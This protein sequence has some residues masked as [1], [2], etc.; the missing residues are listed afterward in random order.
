MI[1]LCYGNKNDFNYNDGVKLPNEEIQRM[2]DKVVEY[3]IEDNK[4][5][6]RF[7]ATGDTMVIG[8]AFDEYDTKEPTSIEIFVCKNY[9]HAI[10]DKYKGNNWEKMNWNYNYDEDNDEYENYT[11]EE[12]I[13]MVRNYQKEPY[14]NPRKEV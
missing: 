12:L 14:Y 7:I 5:G 1:K 6:Y 4:T 13:E 8:F 9:E 2:V 3:L 10:I 11:R